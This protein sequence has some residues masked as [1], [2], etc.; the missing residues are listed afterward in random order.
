MADVDSD[1]RFAA[2]TEDE[3]QAILDNRDSKN[4]KNV[5]KTAEN[6]FSDYLATC[7]M[8]LLLLR[9]MS[10]A[11]LIEILRKF[12]CAARKKDGT[13]YAKKNVNFRTL[14]TPEVL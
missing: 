3:I 9:G 7:D 12:Y 1:T 11:E 8:S 2:A 4:T 14:R 13:M 5:V 6:I 10:C